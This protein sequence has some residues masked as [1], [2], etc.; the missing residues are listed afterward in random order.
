MQYHNIYSLS[1]YS[2]I[3]KKNICLKQ[4]SYIY[5]IKLIHNITT[6]NN[7]IVN[8]NYIIFCVILISLNKK[9]ILIFIDLQ[10]VPKMCSLCFLKI[11]FQN[12]NTINI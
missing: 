11:F 6:F 5:K 8:T 12:D 10:I 4:F 2:Q 1:A 9:Y 3:L 7:I